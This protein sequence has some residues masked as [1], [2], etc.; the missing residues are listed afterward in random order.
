MRCSPCL[1][2]ELLCAPKQLGHY[3]SPED[4]AWDEWCLNDEEVERIH[5]ENAASPEEAE[6]L[7]E[8]TAEEMVLDVPWCLLFHQ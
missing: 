6:K 8:M 4:L 5:L 3:H 1:G 7:E 2:G